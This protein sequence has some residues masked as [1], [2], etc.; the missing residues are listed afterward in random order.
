[1]PSP[2]ARASSKLKA[3]GVLSFSDY[4][5]VAFGLIH[6][7]SKNWRPVINEISDIR[8]LVA[9]CHFMITK[10]D[11]SKIILFVCCGILF[12]YG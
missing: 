10:S 9:Y 6:H 8:N 2:L 7:P 12:F 11:Y 1:M 5:Y 4:V 3:D